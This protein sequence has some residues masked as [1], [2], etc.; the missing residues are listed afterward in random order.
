LN[1]I[2]INLRFLLY[3]EIEKNDIFWSTVEITNDL[4]M[5]SNDGRLF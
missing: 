4:K 1:W 5:P 2:Q 3:N